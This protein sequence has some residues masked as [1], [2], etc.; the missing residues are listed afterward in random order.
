MNSLPASVD[1][2]TDRK[3]QDTIAIEFTDRTIL[4]IARALLISNLLY[5][6]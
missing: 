5:D 1:Y 2:L 6:F 3:I 4:C